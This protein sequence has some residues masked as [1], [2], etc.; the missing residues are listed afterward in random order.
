MVKVRFIKNH[1]SLEKCGAVCYEAGDTVYCR[2]LY[3]S[4]P[5]VVLRASAVNTIDWGGLKCD[6]GNCDSIFLL[7]ISPTTI[8]LRVP[9]ETEKQKNYLEIQ[10]CWI[11]I[12]VTF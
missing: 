5:S 8:L 12:S 7:E 6:I 10:F 11:K 3:H 1:E 9:E 2:W 4:L